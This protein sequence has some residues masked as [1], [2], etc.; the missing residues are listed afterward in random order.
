MSNRRHLRLPGP[1]GAQ[2]GGAGP[3]AGGESEERPG[4]ARAPG[5]G[6]GRA[7]GQPP[8]RAGAGAQAGRA[9]ARGHHQPRVLWP[10]RGGGDGDQDVLQGQGQGRQSGPQRSNRCPP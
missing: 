6:D 10:G 9:P 5:P 8:A 3:A 1:G 7:G 4:Q 2:T